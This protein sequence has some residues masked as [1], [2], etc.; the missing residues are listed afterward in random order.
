MKV[1]TLNIL[2]LH[3]WIFFNGHKKLNVSLSH[4]WLNYCR[5]FCPVCLAS[6][7]LHCSLGLPFRRRGEQEGLEVVNNLT[8][9][10]LPSSLFRDCLQIVSNTDAWLVGNYI[11]KTLIGSLRKDVL[12]SNCDILT[13]TNQLL[14]DIILIQSNDKFTFNL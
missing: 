2:W 1:E 8:S 3:I 6:A 14:D 4:Q 5:L 7:S 13:S 9:I 12:I 10:K 11:I